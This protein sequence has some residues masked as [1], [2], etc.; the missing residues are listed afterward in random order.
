MRKERV[1]RSSPVDGLIDERDSS[2]CILKQKNHKEM[3]KGGR[4]MEREHWTYRSS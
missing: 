2:W 1:E 3:R 4:E